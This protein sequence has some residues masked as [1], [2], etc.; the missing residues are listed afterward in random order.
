M[1]FVAIC[2]Y[3][4]YSFFDTT[5]IQDFINLITNASGTLAGF[6]FT[7]MTILVGIDNELIKNLKRYGH[8]KKLLTEMFVLI[9]GLLL[10]VLL[11]GV[12]ILLPKQYKIVMDK[13]L[14]VL[15]FVAAIQFSVTFR[16][17][18]LIIKISAQK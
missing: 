11:G 3:Y 16:R 8:F 9:V 14:F 12:D 15:F 2:A 6:L 10:L 4:S 13:T 5:H 18:Y 17:F 7:C 1:V